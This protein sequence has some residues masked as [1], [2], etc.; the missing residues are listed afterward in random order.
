MTI[1]EVFE[2]PE[3]K[4]IEIE[5][6]DVAMDEERSWRN[7]QGKVAIQHLLSLRRQ[8]L[9]RMFVMTYE[10]KQLLAE[11]N[12][13]LIDALTKMRRQTISMRDGVIAANVQGIETV[14]KVYMNYKYP[15]N[16]PVQ[17]MRAKKIWGI[18]NNSYDTYMPMYEDGADNL[19]LSEYGEVPSVNQVLYLS[20]DVDNWNEGLDQEKTADMHLCHG[21][22]NLIDHN[23][24][25]IF[26]L[27]W[28]RD[29][30]I[31]ITCESKHCTGS[32]DWDDID[33]R[34]CDYYD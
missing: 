21:F 27:L 29:F 16:H 34:K 19:T 10:Y 6:L 18:I 2:S 23:D 30:S 11:F 15:E 32:E 33:W 22:H 20:E 5:I 24:F 17:T 13:K 8:V 25:S 7:P 12:E 26:D 14:G 31:E 9:N 28:V 3:V 1:Q 4:A